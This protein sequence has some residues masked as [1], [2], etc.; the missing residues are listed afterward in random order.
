MANNFPVGVSYTDPEVLS[1]SIGNGGFGY[2]QGAR[3]SVTQLTDKTTTVGT[4]TSWLTRIT[5]AP[6][7]INAG[8][9]VSFL[10]NNPAMTSQSFVDAAIASGATQGA[11]SITVVA[12]AQGTGG[13]CRID[14]TNLTAG[15]LSEALILTVVV[16]G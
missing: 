16:I 13:G 5:M 4:R 6:S 7:A 3:A 11:Y 12:V 14:I 1:C 10:F 15:A 8:Q 9:T 2:S